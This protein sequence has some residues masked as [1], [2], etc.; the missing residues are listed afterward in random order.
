MV[1]SGRSWIASKN[2]NAEYKG[3]PCLPVV[4]LYIIPPENEIT[5]LWTVAGIEKIINNTNVRWGG[6]E[7]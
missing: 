1:A 7:G 2:E 6:P 5:A 4:F 3:H